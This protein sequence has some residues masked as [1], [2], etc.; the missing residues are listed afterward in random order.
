MA[1]NKS[2][3][4][5]LDGSTLSE[6]GIPA[7]ARLAKATGANLHLVTVATAPGP[8]LESELRGYLAAHAEA[9]STT[10]GVRVVSSLI[11][12]SAAAALAAY[13]EEHK[14]DLIVMTTHGRGGLSRFWLGSVA[15][16]LVRR[17]GVPVLLFRPGTAT[18]P[19][20]FHCVLIALD[21]SPRTEAS[22][23]PA[24]FLA[25]TTPGSRVVLAHVVESAP[26][27]LGPAF[28]EDESR[29]ITGHLEQIAHRLQARGLAVT[30]RIVTGEGIAAH[31]H[32]LAGSEE[33]DLIVV[34][35]HG[36]YGAERL[37]FGSVADKVVRGA[38]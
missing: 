26:G 34:G 1:A 2:F 17:T 22:I 15:D 8:H 6:Q 5:P 7:A 11:R 3:L 33:A 28:L 27:L 25:R 13:A 14:I 20:Q 35:T 10:H 19:G 29:R 37:V 31:L 30:A 4:V 38:T 36:A 32:A 16:R 9:L 12:G 23:A 24:L 18:P 21:G